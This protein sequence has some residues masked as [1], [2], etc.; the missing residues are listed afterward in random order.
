MTTFTIG[1]LCRVLVS[2]VSRC[3]IRETDTFHRV[4]DDMRKPCI[5]HET[6]EQKG[7]PTNCDH[8][9]PVPKRRT[10]WL[11]F[12]AGSFLFVFVCCVVVVVVVFVVWHERL[13]CR[14]L[15]TRQQM[16]ILLHLAA[17]MVS[18][19]HLTTDHFHLAAHAGVSKRPNVTGTAAVCAA[20]M[21]QSNQPA[22]GTT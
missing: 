13:V 18:A 21:M 16:R 14:K 17:C 12:T 1:H 9:V 19:G 5:F 15:R 20:T 10:V 6:W 8:F 22:S 3:K 2:K 11:A 7:D 4:P